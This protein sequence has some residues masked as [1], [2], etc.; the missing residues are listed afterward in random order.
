MAGICRSF[1]STLVCCG[2][3]ASPPK[4]EQSQEAAQEGRV[5]PAPVAVKPKPEPLFFNFQQTFVQ[6]E[7]EEGEGK[8]D[9]LRGLL[10]TFAHEALSQRFLD[11]HPIAA[12]QLLPLMAKH[13]LE[14]SIW[15]MQTVSKVMLQF[16][17]L[18]LFCRNALADTV[19]IRCSDGQVSS[20]R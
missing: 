20:N 5:V 6:I 14:E 17:R 9:R 3:R 7:K 12:V 18:K 19:I 1:F 10:E 15:A 8:S 2:Y 16:R 11:R 13:V 4:Q